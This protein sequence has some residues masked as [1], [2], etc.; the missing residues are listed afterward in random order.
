MRL[1]FIYTIFVSLLLAFLFIGYSAGPATQA[2]QGYI[3]APGESGVSCGTC[4]GN[5]GPYGIVTAEVEAFKNG[6]IVNTYTPGEEYDIIVTIN[7]TT[8]VPAGFGFQIVALDE[9]ENNS[10]IFS[11]PD[12]NTKIVDL[13]G[14]YYAEHDGISSTNMFSFKWT[15]PIL[16]TGA[17]NFYAAGNAVN[18]DGTTMGDTGTGTTPGRLVL[19][20]E[21]ALS[22]ELVVFTA[23]KRFNSMLLDWTTATETNSDYFIV[24]YSKDGVDFDALEE[25]KAAGNSTSIINYNYRHI[26][27][28]AGNNY[29]RL[30]Q[31]DI[32]GMRTYSNVIVVK[33]EEIAGDIVYAYPNPIIDKTNLFVRYKGKRTYST[34]LSLYNVAGQIIYERPVELEPGENWLELDIADFPKGYYYLS[35]NGAEFS[36]QPLRLLKI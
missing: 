33:M 6:T 25:I 2:G 26:N 34:G 28:V 23:E 35:V 8:S 17:V 3:G 13:N 7:Y 29:Y 19:S 36:D 4:H 11:S 30:A 18:G 32:S 22:T 24:E 21:A 1:Q 12:A 15:A 27:P 31:M 10:G 14:R 20:P 16:Q 5:P 9:A